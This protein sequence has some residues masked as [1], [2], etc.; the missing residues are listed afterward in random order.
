MF[1]F[2]IYIIKLQFYRFFRMKLI[3]T[4]ITAQKLKESYKKG[5]LSPNFDYS[6]PKELETRYRAFSQEARSQ[7]ETQIRSNYRNSQTFNRSEKED[8]MKSLI[9]ANYA[10]L[11][12]DKR[13]GKLHPIVKYCGN[14]LLAAIL[15]SLVLKAV[16]EV[17]KG[18]NESTEE[19]GYSQ[20]L[21]KVFGIDE[22][23]LRNL[24]GIKEKRAFLMTTMNGTI[25]KL[26]KNWKEKIETREKCQ[27][28]ENELKRNEN[29]DS[30]F[31]FLRLKTK[32]EALR[33][34]LTSTVV[35]KLNDV[36]INPI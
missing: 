6:N 12:E 34:K 17:C 2:L 27:S 33:K 20:K 35:Q 9:K 29:L 21:L 15:D 30:P 24:K 4:E 28:N 25:D 31:A 5:I 32:Y 18:K 14:T 13:P 36:S 7:L 3:T 8:N 16:E 26:L 19:L 23:Q 10:R 1:F 11:N 22:F